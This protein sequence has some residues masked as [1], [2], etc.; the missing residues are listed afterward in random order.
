V[1]FGMILMITLFNQETFYDFQFFDSA[2]IPTLFFFVQLPV[3]CSLLE[4]T[5][6]VI[7]I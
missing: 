2:L 1:N 6:P 3:A 7:Q 4:F 5:Q